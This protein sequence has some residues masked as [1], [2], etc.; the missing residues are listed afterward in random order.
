M[1]PN[2]TTGVFATRRESASAR[3]HLQ[4]AEAGLAPDVP[5]PRRLPFSFPAAQGRL[6]ASSGPAIG[7]NSREDAPAEAGAQ[8][9]QGRLPFSNPGVSNPG[10][11]RRKGDRPPAALARGYRPGGGRGG[12]AKLPL[13]ITAILTLALLAN[14]VAAGFAA[15][16]TGEVTLR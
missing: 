5:G 12:A 10:A 1:K 8:H 7:R 4:A 15:L 9:Q 2:P 3:G 6:A 11:Q 16:H 13:I 14:P